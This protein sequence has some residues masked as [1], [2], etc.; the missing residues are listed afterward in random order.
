L[1][2]FTHY[3]WAF[4]IIMTVTLASTLFSISY[5]ATLEAQ[6]KD[7]WDNDVKGGDAVQAAETA[8]LS[9]ESAV[10][11]LMVYTDRAPRDR[12]AAEVQA[13]LRNLK[14]LMAQAEPRFHTPKARGALK[15][16]QEDLKPF[17][18]AV[19]EALEAL[20]PGPNQRATWPRVR[21]R[22]DQ[23]QRDFALLI[24]NRSANSAQGIGELIERLRVSLVLTVV[25]L[26]ITVAVRVIL[27][28]A[29]HPGRRKPP[30]DGA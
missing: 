25:L 29:G 10:K 21:T 9:I 14:T 16:T 13:G 27:Y 12:A 20:G 1:A 5:L 7:V 18:D 24:A 6:L 11:D 8:V 17:V 26:V 19:G 15:K 28:I 23:L 3:T 22:V 2:F 30:V 4:A